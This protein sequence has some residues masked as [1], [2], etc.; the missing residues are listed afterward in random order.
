MGTMKNPAR[1]IN[2]ALKQCEKR[3]RTFTDLSSERYWEQDE[4]CRFTLVSGSTSEHAIDPESLVGTF[5]WDRGAVPVGDG[6]SW[7]KHKAVLQARQP[8]ADFLF[9]RFDSKGEL[10]YISASGEPVFDDKRRFCG[11]HGIAKDVTREKREE[12][13]LRL[14]HTVTRS[15]AVAE[16]ALA[17]LKAVIRAVC[18]TEGWDGGV[19]FRMDDEAKLL[20]LSPEECWSIENPAVKRYVGGMRAVISPGVGLAGQVW[21]SGQAL[22]VTDLGADAR[23]TR[24][25]LARETGMH[26]S[27]IFPVI[28][29]GK[30]IGVLAF[31]SRELRHPEERLL[32]AIHVI[33]SQLGQFVQRKQAEDI[34]RESQEQL[35]R[36]RAAMD[37]SV[38]LVLLVDRTT[39]RYLDFNQTV[40]RA[41]GYSREELLKLGPEDLVLRPRDLLPMGREELERAH[42]EL[43][44][45]PG[46]HTGLRVVYRCKDGSL[47]PV[48]V[49]RTALSSGSSYITVVISRDIR[50]QIAAEN[51]LRESE[52]RFRSLTQ[53]SSDVYWEQDDQ[54]R[55][56]SIAGRG[57]EQ[58][59][60][61]DFQFIGKKPWELNYLNMSA[62]DWA[63]HMAILEAHR[64]F[65]DLE[66]CQQNASGKKAWVAVSGEPAFDAAGAFKGYHGVGKDISERKQAEERIQY[67]ANHDTLTSLPNRV[68]FSEVLKLALQNARRYNGT[69]AVLF[70]DLDRFKIIN[71]TLG[72]EAGDK[73]LQEMG[74]RLSQAVRTSDVVA[75]LGGDEF[76][77][78]VREV[79]EPKQVEA[80]ARKILSALIKPMFIREQECSVTASIGICMYPADAQDEQSLMKNAD[81]AMY[82][83]KEEG[84]N[85]YKYYSEESNVHSFER[86]ALETSLRRGLER[87]EFFLDYQAN[88]DLHTGKI[89]GVEAL[90]RW[91]HPELGM[92]PPAQFIPLAEE[93]GLIVPIGKWVLNT[94]C[95]QNVAW[96]RVGLP[97]LRM[98]VNLSARQFADEDLLKHIAGALGESGMKPELLEMELTENMMMQ[99]AER[100]GK[101]LAAIKRLGVRLAI[102]DF[103][104]GY[105]SLANLKRFPIDTL[106]VDRSFIR[107][108]PQDSEDNAI[109]RAIIAM[110]KSLNLTVVA[111]GVE[112]LEQEAFLRE[113]GCDETQGYYFSK[114]IA[115]NQFAELLRRHIESPRKWKSATGE[116]GVGDF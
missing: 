45:N 3:F 31:F 35:R 104:V 7:D 59:K 88:R 39:M 70:I 73:L 57:L 50:E 68:M 29:E 15:L 81:I 109:T 61:R 108:I 17:P 51:A 11:Y 75:R 48:E 110:G 28:S 41:L 9:K 42:D 12:L 13:M 47:L 78:L 58:V 55:F 25:K 56:T 16:G 86:M 8:F 49:T 20:R 60:A 112:T 99:N 34:L 38:D 87:D 21:Q 96:Q 23:A 115:G 36:F 54:Y 62:D 65:H 89:T 2:E 76:V 116:S 84:K 64:P 93:T 53:L 72:H 37:S 43:I 4:N 67:V 79:G 92:V 33:G 113:H 1:D 30:T 19:Y 91:Q 26:G 98:A 18:E 63:A 85:T 24:S 69:F 97:P 106:K 44:A 10:R 46:V 103:G 6:G 14:E 94:A 102:D 83:A 90:V 74:A 107:N 80:V 77:V 66:L 101:V 22:W 40:C 32:Q 82:R 71:D 114:P 52:E 27:F 5:R 105:S 100:A 95:A 111:E